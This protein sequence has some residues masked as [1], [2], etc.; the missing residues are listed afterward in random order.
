MFILT[1][2][3]LFLHAHAAIWKEHG[4]LNVHNSPIKYG[5]QILSLLE[6]ILKPSLVTVV[7][8]QG[9]QRGMNEVAKK[10][11]FADQAAH[12]VALQSLVLQGALVS[13]L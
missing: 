11:Q 3:F 12:Q 6:E 10:N 9:H 2:S 7:Y 4:Y 1:L 5:P 13:S 8:Y